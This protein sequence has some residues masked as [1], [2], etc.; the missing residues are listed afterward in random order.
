MSWQSCR[1]VSALQLNGM[2]W[3]GVEWNKRYRMLLPCL[4][5]YFWLFAAPKAIHAYLRSPSCS[6]CTCTLGCRVFTSPAP[7]QRLLDNYQSWPMRLSLSI[8]HC[9]GRGP[10]SYRSLPLNPSTVSLP[11]QYLGTV[12]WLA[13]GLVRWAPRFSSPSRD[14]D[15]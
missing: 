5:G 13:W 8:G 3:S 15:R 12:P 1:L 4:L 10:P 2:E 14:L 6:S 11:R 9:R 7:R